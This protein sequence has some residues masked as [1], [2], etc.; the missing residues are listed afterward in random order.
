VNTVF[1]PLA[2]CTKSNINIKIEIL[3][4]IA[5]NVVIIVGKESYTSGDQKWNGAEETLNKYPVDNIISARS[6]D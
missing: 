5:T 2:K 3:A 4:I 1:A 6:K